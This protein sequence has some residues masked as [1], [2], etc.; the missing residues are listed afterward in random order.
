MSN[1]LDIGRGETGNPR[2]D[3]YMSQSQLPGVNNLSKSDKFNPSIIQS[4]KVKY[5][6]A[7]GKVVK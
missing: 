4:I 5:L 1:G 7:K 2:K 3:P 6:I